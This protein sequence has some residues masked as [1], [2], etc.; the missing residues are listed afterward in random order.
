MSGKRVKV[1]V[2]YRRDGRYNSARARVP[3]EIRDFLRAECG[4]RLVFEEGSKESLE[5]AAKHNR[6]Y[7]VVYLAPKVKKASERESVPETVEDH[8][9]DESRMPFCMDSTEQLSEESDGPQPEGLQA[10]EEAVRRKF[11]GGNING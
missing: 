6:G 9:I 4:D 3:V 5:R 11:Q 2:K 10:L 7:F 8:S 1:V